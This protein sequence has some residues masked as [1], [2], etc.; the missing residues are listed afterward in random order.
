[1]PLIDDFRHMIEHDTTQ[2]QALL[3][4]LATAMPRSVEAHALLATSHMR[5]LEYDTALA[6]Y[7]QILVL[8]PRNDDALHNVGFCLLA[9]G[10]NEGGMAAYR[11]AFATLS[12]VAALRKIALLLHRSGR[13]Q[14]A[15]ASYERILSSANA[16]SP[17]IPYAIRGLALALRD[18]G[19]PLAADRQIQQ[20]LDRF[21]REPA[22][23]ALGFVV[24]NTS[25]DFH[26][27]TAYVDKA[28]LGV[29]LMKR[30]AVD[31]AG[32]VPD[33]FILPQDRQALLAHAASDAAAPLY[34]V[35]P[36]RSSGGQGISVTADVA[37]AIDRDDVVVQRYLDRPY[38][39]DGRKSHVR[40]YCL[41]TSAAPLRAYV[42]SEGVVRFA[43]ER[44][45]PTP[46]RLGGASMHITNTA[47]HVGHPD[48]V[49]SQD[50]SQEDV[51]VIWSLSA[52]LRRITAQNDSGTGDDGRA[53]FAEIKALVEW[54]VRML[55]AEGLFARQAAA[56]Q[57]RGFT[58]KL[59]GLDVL[60]DADGHPWLIEMQ[61]SPATSGA[62]LVNKIN[63]VLHATLFKMAHGLLL[64]DGASPDQVARMMSDPAAMSE[65]ELQI[66]QANAGLFVPL[67]L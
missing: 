22:S 2:A 42:Y 8:D 5:R 59:F 52:L 3:R 14:D 37:T 30:L 1:L 54:Y 7:R 15:I 46:D 12:S 63:G 17:E 38:L 11:H 62:P 43:P 21:R 39:V 9:L 55:A 4:T 28:R 58:H 20:L 51:G 44:Y 24:R 29:A 16:T 41:I 13:L 64:E 60:I 67:D 25:E 50:T 6:A 31:P 65:R 57:A 26:E 56:S 10:D 19:R 36:I 48:L 32:R 40:I 47:L 66:E 34:I 53:V 61:R 45:E 49:I 18:A 35:K 33:T 23:Y 27:W